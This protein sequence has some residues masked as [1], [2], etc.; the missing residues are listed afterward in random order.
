MIN[1][2]L[3]FKFHTFDVMIYIDKDTMPDYYD[4]F[5]YSSTALSLCTK[6]LNTPCVRLQ[7]KLLKYYNSSLSSI[8]LHSILFSDLSPSNQLIIEPHIQC[9]S[10]RGHKYG[11]EEKICILF[12][13]L[14]FSP[15]IKSSPQC[16]A[17][18][19]LLPAV[20]VKQ[21]CHSNL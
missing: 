2:G 18:P 4:Y 16:Y 19:R 10:L 9:K 17:L 7:V 11:N 12:F 20:V 5:L 8:Y 3:H 1:I 21:R 15:C 6:Y 14:I 13:W